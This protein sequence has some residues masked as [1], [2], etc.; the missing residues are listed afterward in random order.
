MAGGPKRAEPPGGEARAE[1]TKGPVGE[2]R[3]QGVASQQPETH[4]EN[5]SDG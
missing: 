4:T 1:G 5:G 3:P 2:K